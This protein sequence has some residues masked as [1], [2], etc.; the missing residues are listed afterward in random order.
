MVK[1]GLSST[2]GNHEI[3]YSR[4]LAY[5]LLGGIAE[6]G[7]A[8]VELSFLDRMEGLKAACRIDSTSTY[9]EAFL[10]G[11]N[12]GPTSSKYERALKAAYRSTQACVDENKPKGRDYYKEEISKRPELKPALAA[13]Y[14]SWSG[15]ID[16]LSSPHDGLEESAEKTAYEA[17]LNRLIAE[18]DAL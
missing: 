12:N 9:N 4:Y 8:K 3:P 11:R 13:F 16:W 10:V 6:A 2:D 7:T 14:G 15:Y 5:V 17:S 1:F 18:I